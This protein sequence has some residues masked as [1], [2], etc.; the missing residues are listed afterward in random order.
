MKVI[1]PVA[2]EG[3]RLRPH[4]HTIPKVLINIA[5]KP[6]ISYIID[7]LKDIPNVEFIFILG[8][9]GEK[10]EEFL[11]SEYK[12]Q[13]FHCIYQKEQLGLGHAI[14]QASSKMNDDDETLIVLGDTIFDTNYDFLNSNHSILGVK[15]VKDPRR[16]GVAVVENGVIKKLVEKPQDFVSDL[17]LVGIYFI[18]QWK[19]LEN[20]LNYIINNGI[21]TKNEFQLTDA[22]QDMIQ[23]GEIFNTH[24]I[25]GWYDCGKP[26]T[27]I[28]TTKILLDKKSIIKNGTNSVFIKPCYI[29][30]SAKIVD[31]IIGPYVSVGE[32]AII[33][34]SIIRD[35]LVDKDAELY[36]VNL[37]NSLIGANAFVKGQSR[38]LNIG[39]SSEVI[40]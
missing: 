15:K 24:N 2:G 13:T 4:T 30:A 26:E 19:S 1:I 32:N 31:S 21:M 20:S 33:E 40:Y 11:N 29:P 18:K 36:N 39:D 27:L 16:F 14:Y 25:E 7:K 28:S 38:S 9:L 34:S 37:D 6:I 22:L 12:E 3:T 35:S 8:Y 23:N 17:A 5:G 10:V